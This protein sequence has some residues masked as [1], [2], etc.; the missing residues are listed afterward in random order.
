MA[1]GLLKK[2]V[3]QKV[4][5]VGQ[6]LAQLAGKA[7]RVVRLGVDCVE[8]RG[9]EKLGV[10][11]CERHEPVVELGVLA[12]EG[13]AVHLHEPLRAAQVVLDALEQQ[14][15]GAILE[16]AAAQHEVSPHAAH[17]QLRVHESVAG[18]H[19][20]EVAHVLVAVHRGARASLEALVPHADAVHRH[21]GGVAAQAILHVVAANEH[22][23]RKAPLADVRHRDAREP[24]GAVGVLHLDV[25]ALVGND[26]VEAI[27]VVVGLE[28]GVL[29]AAKHVAH[30]LEQAR[31][32]LDGEHR[33]VHERIRVLVARKRQKVIGALDAL[34]EHVNVIVH[35]DDVRE[36]LLGVE[37]REHAAGKSARAAHVG[38]GNDGD[39][40]VGERLG[41][42]GLAVVDDE[43]VEVVVN[44]AAILGDACAHELDVGDDVVL[45]L[46][47]RRGKG[48]AHRAHA[49]LV[50]A[51]RVRA[52]MKKRLPGRQE[53]EGNEVHACGVN[54]GAYAGMRALLGLHGEAVELDGALGVCGRTRGKALDDDLAGVAGELEGERDLVNA[55][56]LCPLSGG[57]GVQEGH[58]VRGLANNEGPRR[59]VIDE[60]RGAE[61]VE[62]VVTLEV[63]GGL[64][65]DVRE[66][67]LDH[68]RSCALSRDD[69]EF[70]HCSC[71]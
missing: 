24:P 46:E 17:E 11:V 27:H 29:A 2:G 32:L 14:L 65:Q 7:D 63:V 59:L 19:D 38:V 64:E 49:V 68:G 57:A 1:G 48:D 54:R 21:V 36:G 69:F 70:R 41:I 33:A 55:A 4:L 6:R 20:E 47:R 37:G 8:V 62:L 39:E 71:R 28:L 67:V 5:V 9:V 50:D 40:L 25:L 23:Q 61:G 43:H 26:L 56:V 31:G 66:L 3:W 34:G 53:L 12:H 30:V 18:G 16:V 51:R 52:R 44:G 10:D 45:L 35:E 60:G 42:K 13:A 58:E 22:G 15:G